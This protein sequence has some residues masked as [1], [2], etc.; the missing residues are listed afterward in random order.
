M[1]TVHL[2]KDWSGEYA[3]A[4]V[5]FVLFFFPKELFA[6]SLYFLMLDIQTLKKKAFCFY[7]SLQNCDIIKCCF[8]CLFLSIVIPGFQDCGFSSFFLALTLYFGHIGI[9]TEGVTP[10][11]GFGF[12]LQHNWFWKNKSYFF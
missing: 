1:I 8:W 3:S 9:N 5:C 2:S 4:C 6:Y 12:L 11:V 7:Y 10:I